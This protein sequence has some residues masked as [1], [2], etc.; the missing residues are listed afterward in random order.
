MPTILP[1]GKQRY[2]DNAGLALVGGKVYAYDAGT[3]TPRNT[4]SD[5][6]GTLNPWPVILDARGEALIYWSGAYKVVVKDAADVVIYTVD[7]IF[8]SNYSTDQLR[9]DLANRAVAAKGA[10]LIGFDPTVAY[11]VGT[12]G[13]Y[14]VTK[15]DVKDYG[16]IGTANPAN[17]AADTIAFSLAKAAGKQV[18]VP[19]GTFYLSAT[20]NIDPGHSL[21]GA[22]TGKTVIYYSGAGNGIYMGAPGDTQLAYDC[23]LAGITLICTNRATTVNGVYGDNLV[24]FSIDDMTIIGS[25]NPN[26]G[27]P[28]DRVLYGSGL[29]LTNNSIIGRVNRVSCRIWNYG[30]W[31]KCLPASQSFW[32]AAIACDGQGELANNMRGIV[33]GDPA[34]A[35]YSG[36]SCTFR[37]LSIQGNYT[38]GINI[39]TGD[40]TVIDGCYFE[41]NANYDVAIGTPGGAPNPIGTKVINNSMSTEGIGVTPYGNF[42]YLA[43]VYVDRGEGTV[44]ENNNMSVSTAIPLV[45]VAA[46]ANDTRI[47]KNRLNSSAATTARISDASTTTVT[48]DNIPEAPRVAIGTFTRL[49]SAASGPVAVAGLGFRPKSI[50]FVCAVDTT[51][52]N[53]IGFAGVGIGFQNRCISRDGAGAQLSSNDCIRIIKAAAGNEQKATLASLDADGFTLNWVLVGAPPANN[54]IVNYIARR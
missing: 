20:Y 31:F 21:V 13:A 46:T 4:Y 43:K 47:F 25:G 27:V 1:Q 7:N 36:V 9:A 22:G 18:R 35:F 32:T 3:N 19:E 54:L 49:L 53:S 2:V 28:A 40:N 12:A 14:A 50:E 39:H 44:I 51:V 16:A 37:N 15:A 6:A 24:Y 29:L 34:I 5:S 42:P 26:S 10:G 38:T 23:A 41:G 33:V 48:A 45:L 52:E 17:E 8:D 30:Y 11:G